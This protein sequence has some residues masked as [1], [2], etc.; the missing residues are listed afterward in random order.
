[1]DR[2]DTG[3]ISGSGV[4]ELL[5][6]PI[7]LVADLYSIQVLIWDANFQRLYCAQAGKNFHVSDPVLSTEFGVYHEA[8][9]W[10]WA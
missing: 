3:T 10:S 7:K 1:M 6:P 9:R 4:I 8:A 2:F 5:T